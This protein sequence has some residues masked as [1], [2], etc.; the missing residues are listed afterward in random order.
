MPIPAAYTEDQLA[1]YMH[2]A[3]GQ[4]ADV[5]GLNPVS[6][7][8]DAVIDTLLA[9]GAQNISQATD[10]AKLRTLA[11]R[12]AWRLANDAAA[13]RYDVNIDGAQMARSQL[14]TQIAAGLSRAETD[15]LAYDTGYSGQQTTVAYRDAYKDCG[16]CDAD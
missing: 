14:H 5:L 2:R 7:Y 10:M 3:L 16:D 13:T 15:A 8:G 1:L 11:R 12:E 9:Y 6:D 4:V